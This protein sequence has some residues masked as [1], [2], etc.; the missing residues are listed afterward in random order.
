MGDF[1]LIK[2][3]RADLPAPRPESEHVA[4]AA[5]AARF[6]AAGGSAKPRRRRVL[7]VRSLAFAG[8]LASV[9]AA[10]TI[11]L[12][13]GGGSG[14]KPETANAAD[15]T[16]LA[17]LAPHLGIAGGWQITHTEVAPDGGA[18]RFSYVARPVDAVEGPTEAEMQWHIGTVAELGRRLEGE[19]L[20]AAGIMPT[21]TIDARAMRE[22][23]FDTTFTKGTAQVY[24]LR[25]DGRGAMRAVGLWEEDG[26]T[27]EL[28]AAVEDPEMLER[29]LERVEILG[30]REWEIALRPGGAMWLRDSLD[31]TVQKV[32]N[33]TSER[34]DGSIVHETIMIS[35]TPQQREELDF[36]APFPV[37][38][39]EG[40]KIRV[41]VERAPAEVPES[42]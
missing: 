37:I 24:V 10:A 34:P 38:H 19:G 31:G 25:E 30:S 1:E 12:G 21:V 22:E 32:E 28:S 20:E 42:P 2:Q 33:V 5:L 6:E 4:R 39:R 41:E 36:T 16:E 18:T 13:P 29:L 8:A 15:L 35:K 3:L 11:V 27:L 40:D 9:A 17:A 7:R 23:R 14:V 26:W